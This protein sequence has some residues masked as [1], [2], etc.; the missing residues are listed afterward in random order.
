MTRRRPAAAGPVPANP[1]DAAQLVD[2]E[3]LAGQLAEAMD[4]VKD[5]DAGS[6]KG[7]IYFKP[8]ATGP[9][10]FCGDVFPPFDNFTEV[11]ADL[12]ERF[13]GGDYE[14]RVTAA[15][16]IRKG[17]PFT[18]ARE[19][20]GFG[21]HAPAPAA[22]PAADRFGELVMLMMT[23]QQASA[24]RTMNMMIEGQKSQATLLAAVIPALAGGGS[25]GT[26]AADTIALVAALQGSNKGGGLKDTIEAM[27]AMQVLLEGGKRGESE[28]GE[29]FD[30]DNLVA[31]AGRLAGPVLK[32]VADYLQ[33]NRDP[34]AP[35]ASGQGEPAAGGGG[36]PGQ[37][38][39]GGGGSRFRII[40]LVKVDVVYGYERGHDPE[41][42]AEL[43]YDVIEANNVTEAEITELATTFA[44][45]PT[46]LD[47]LAA[48]GIDLRERPQWAHEF[49]AAIATIHSG[50]TDNSDGEPGSPANPAGDGPPSEEGAPRPAH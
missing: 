24:D 41:K 13:G 48:E 14:L 34:A 28:A 30:A 33:R 2:M 38:A 1:F 4:A 10:Q 7:I 42:I 45:S 37:L 44:L 16:R 27:T 29:G 25:K 9:W 6:I 12:R 35:S 32:S 20:A 18:I 46:G 8:N 36:A 40:E 5:F 23:Q 3:G 17:V 15:G 11:M 39:L 50:E 22:A 47:D 31:T 19:K 43:V 49:F 26:S 21:H